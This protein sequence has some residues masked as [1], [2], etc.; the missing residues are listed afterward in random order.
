MGVDAHEGQ[1]STL[2]VDDCF[3]RQDARFLDLVRAVRN[4]KY[5]AGLADRWKQDP[6][7]W[8]REQIFKYLEMPLNR[9]GHHPL[10]KRLFKHA[11]QKGRRRANGRLPRRVRSLSPPPAAD[12]LQVGLSNSP[13]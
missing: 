8:A 13:E 1:P 3:S 11:E 10:V 2:L 7:P 12:E 9:P 6:R 5:L 4:P